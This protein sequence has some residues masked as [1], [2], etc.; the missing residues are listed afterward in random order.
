MPSTWGLRRR[1]T[2]PS[3]E[4]EEVLQDRYA[5]RLDELLRHPAAPDSPPDEPAE[6]PQGDDAS[7]SSPG[8]APPAAA[9]D[10]TLRLDDGLELRP[11]IGRV[12]FRIRPKPP[13]LTVE[14][15]R[16]FGTRSADRA[17]EP[18]TPGGGPEA[19]EP[20]APT[21]PGAGS[22]GHTPQRPPRK[23]ASRRGRATVPAAPPP[24]ACPYCAVLLQPPPPSSRRCPRCR[25][26][27]V[28]KKATDRTV[29]LTEAAVPVF[30]AE[31][32]RAID[33]RRHVHARDRWLRLATTAGAPEDRVRRLAGQLASEAA[34]ETA[35][36]LYMTTVDRA[37]RFARRERRWETAARLRRDQAAALHRVAGR[38]LPPSDEVVALYREGVSAQL[39]GIS[40]VAREAELTGPSCCDA[41]AADQGRVFRIAGERRGPRLPH[42]GCPTGLCRCRWT[43]AV[44]DIDEL[45]RLMR[46]R[47]RPAAAG[48]PEPQP[49]P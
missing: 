5:A 12:P 4:E 36:A 42:A 27:I 38:R 26:R 41:C 37:F 6:V 39:R 15:G 3:E 2:S 46:L 29:Y 23:P 20:A 44:K 19:A 22:A 45:R 34:V 1:P 8:S 40:E 18:E 21:R 13:G 9:Y 48:H 16:P 24:V 35:R 25:Q 17:P 47:S 49:A 14:G 11:A 33:H 30:E 32:R 7:M 43:L 28:V 31:R 10:G